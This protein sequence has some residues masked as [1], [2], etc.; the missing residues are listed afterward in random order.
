MTTVESPL[1]ASPADDAQDLATPAEVGGQREVAT[2]EVA[3][4]DEAVEVDETGAVTEG[5]A[6]PAA[7][8]SPEPEAEVEPRPEA[9]RRK[10]GD[11]QGLR[12]LAVA[13]VVA[14]HMG[15]PGM[16]GGFLG[17][18]VFFVISGFL[19]TGLLVHEAKTRGR[20]SLPG[21]WARRARRVLPAA[22]GVL[23]ATLAT[24]AYVGSVSA[25]EQAGTDAIWA[26][27][28]LANLHLVLEG[29][30]Y[31]ASG[32]ASLFQHYW[33]LAVEEQFYLVWPLLLLVMVR[34]RARK[35]MILAIVATV[36][37]ASLA[38]SL[39]VTPI[40]AETAYFNTLAR[41]FEFGG[42]AFLAVMAPR[43]PRW[44]NALLGIVGAA[45]L[46]AACATMTGATPF[47]GWHAGIPVLAT[48]CLLAAPTGPVSTVLRIWPLRA[49]GTI[50]Y[51]VYL[52][53][54]PVLQLAPDQ[55]PEGW[56]RTE[57]DLAMV[58]I[59]L[60]LSI[61]SWAVLEVPFQKGWIPGVRRHGALVLWPL[62]IGLVLSAASASTAYAT[63][64]LDQRNAA[65]AA[66][67]K[68]HAA[69]E[70][71]S[72]SASPQATVT[73]ADEIAGAV[74]DGK[75]GAPLPVF[76]IAAHKK[77]FW[78]TDF[79]C[80]ADN[81]DAVAPSCTYGDTA[82]SALVVV[83][84]DSH[85][86]MWLPALDA[87][88]KEQHF[89]VVPLVKL[90]CAPFFVPQTIGG[91]DFP[92]CASFRRWSVQ[93]IAEL[94]P[95]AVIV[96]YRGLNETSPM[97]GRTMDETWTFGVRR[98]ITQ[99]TPSAGKVIVLGDV[100]TRAESLDTCATTPGNTL[101]SCAIPATGS[102]ITSNA[103][104]RAALSGTSATYVDTV[105]LVCA[106]GTCPAA[107]GTTWTYRDQDHLT[108][109]WAQHVTA[110]LG[111]D[112]GRIVG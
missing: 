45:G 21:F 34:F 72:A 53:H 106:D 77:D 42:G 61:L 48:M 71:A 40:N 26:S 60:A 43:F 108:A 64:Q 25:T 52:W 66:W 51:S 111:E 83:Q 87:L 32:T 94:K 58:G 18:D 46:I 69:T 104:T 17:V 109:S 74:A 22:T 101:A 19:I 56:N 37:L 95:D 81:P 41:G 78:R 76:D 105:G 13:L 24:T 29:T 93:R 112:L 62:T 55:L 75:A 54:W 27:G 28:F 8:A 16:H 84:G 35:G 67:E 49:L 88:G 31:F 98:L 39:H 110:Q 100:P 86:G 4:V 63:H 33:S 30:D 70:S 36:T 7:E 107:V 15:L 80:F 79:G 99:I 44:L 92:T 9:K 6:S 103:L 38:W 2:G 1:D 82:A 23:V 97:S 47:P 96:G 50:S 3:E 73:L 68:Q 59:I 65:A 102:G 5:A 89:R 85:A 90:G 10:R 57:R 91:A 11:I 14:D 12:A 20:I